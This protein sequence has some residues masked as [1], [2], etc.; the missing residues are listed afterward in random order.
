M[1]KRL[2]LSIIFPLGILH[3]MDPSLLELRRTGNNNS[4]NEQE[5]VLKQDGRCWLALLP[6]EIVKEIIKV[7]IDK[8]CDSLDF[9]KTIV[10][11]DRINKLFYAVINKDPRMIK[12]LHE[13]LE[14]LKKEFLGQKFSYEPMPLKAE[15]TKQTSIS[16]ALS[17]DKAKGSYIQ[18]IERCLASQYELEHVISLNELSANLLGKDH[19]LI[20]ILVCN[21]DPNCT[22]YQ[23]RPLIF[24]LSSN[25]LLDIVKL[26][27]KK[28]ANINA[29]ERGGFTTLMICIVNSQAKIFDLLLQNKADLDIQ[30]E[31]GNCALGLALEFHES[32]M[33]KILID[34]KANVNLKDYLGITPLMILV[35]KFLPEKLDILKLLI[36][37]GADIFALNDKN[38]SAIDLVK[39]SQLASIYKVDQLLK[40]EMNKQCQAVLKDENHGCEICASQFD[41][42]NEVGF[43]LKCNHVFHKDCIMPWVKEHKNCPICKLEVK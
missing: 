23:G 40:A 36:D 21:I 15:T 4:I 2:I 27:I 18:K 37:S 42:E 1:F 38:E 6:K 11:L 24:R 3:S 41:F 35:T 32:N 16:D 12:L 20:W 14:S 17:F 5:I 22:D 25:N 39:E 10:R 28:G 33:A 9:A 19:N 13:K 30:N 43:K 7:T 26:W 31:S 34:K 8:S 29:Q